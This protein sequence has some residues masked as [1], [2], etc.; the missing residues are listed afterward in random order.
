[1]YSL[2][3]NF[4][5]LIN[6]TTIL[7][8]DGKRSDKMSFISRISSVC[9]LKCNKTIYGILGEE[10]GSMSVINVEQSKTVF[11]YRCSDKALQF[12]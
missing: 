11:H 2:G 4:I 6:P 1:M 9:L 10:E 12:I 7:I 8:S 5:G 3:E